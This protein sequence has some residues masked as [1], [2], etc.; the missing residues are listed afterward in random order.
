MGLEKTEK[1]SY[2]RY[3]IFGNFEDVMDADETITS[4]EFLAEDN[5]G[6]DALADILVVGDAYVY[7]TKQYVRVKDGEE[8]KSPYHITIR[9][10]TSKGNRWEVDGQVKVKEK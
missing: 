3:F 5:T 2:E 4:S 7:G 8:A 1:Q 9:I 6:Q 10:E